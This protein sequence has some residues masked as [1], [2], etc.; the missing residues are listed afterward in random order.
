VSDHIKLSL[1]PEA[2]SIWCQQVNVGKQL[3]FSQSGSKYMVV[4]LGGTFLS[5]SSRIESLVLPHN[6][7]SVVY[8]T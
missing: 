6:L 7:C 4:D 2:A 8:L 3:A 5:V 1:E